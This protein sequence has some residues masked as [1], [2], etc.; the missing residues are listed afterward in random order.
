MSEIPQDTLTGWYR[1]DIEAIGQTLPYQLI[2]VV[3]QL[4][5]GN[6]ENQNS[7]ST[8][9]ESQ[10]TIQPRRIQQD[11]SLD[12]GNHLSYALQWF[13]FA[14]TAAVVYIS[15]ARRAETRPQ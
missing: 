11:L 4:V 9:T 5:P 7:R 12:E 15:V 13:G 6:G 10:A 3:L 1:L 14:I 2:P 8:Q